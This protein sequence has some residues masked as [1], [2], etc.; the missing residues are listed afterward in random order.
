MTNKAT[1]RDP[2]LGPART[3]DVDGIPLRVHERGE[4]PAVV[5]VHGLLVNANLWRKVVPALAGS[6]RVITLDLPLGAHA[7]ALPPGTDLTPPALG[8]LIAGAIEALGLEDVTIVGNDTGGGL[9]QIAV[10]RHPERIGA[11]V[12]TSCDAFE[13]FPP[14]MVKP[15]LPPLK[16]PRVAGALFAPMRLGPVQSLFF[17]PLAHRPVERAVRDTWVLPALT[18]AGIRRDIAAVVKDIEPSH[19]LAAAERLA[20]FDRPAIV[21]WSADDMVFTRRHGERLAELLPQGRLELIEGARTFSPE[22]QPEKLAEL[23]AEMTRQA[24]PAAA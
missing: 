10:A 18:D 16:R 6:A 17:K 24:V 19:T 1:Y 2:G 12:L 3:L 14:P 23:I 9:V 13:H 7:E 22:D 11:L 5:L 4:G 20:S 21:A 8:D 15:L